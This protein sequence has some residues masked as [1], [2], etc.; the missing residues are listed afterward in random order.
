[1][2]TMLLLFAAVLALVLLNVPIAVSL[3]VVAV[4]AMAV[5]GCATRP[6]ERIAYNAEARRDAVRIVILEPA[7]PVALVVICFYSLTK[8]F[9]DFTHLYLGVALA[10]APVGAWLAVPR[11]TSCRTLIPSG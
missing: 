4:V 2:A 7:P 9:T 3:G 6:P 11:I 5:A 8:R 1:M 10:L